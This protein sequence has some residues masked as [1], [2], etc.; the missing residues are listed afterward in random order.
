MHA[1]RVA[2]LIVLATIVA[3]GCRKKP[4]TPPDVIVR[5]T[6]RMLTLADFK[7]YLVRNTGTDLA[8]MT[9]EVASALLDQF[10][11]EIIL[12]EY[13][14][15]HGVEVPAER[16]AEAV[17]TEAGS[18]V[19]EKRDEM[20]RQKLMS[21]VTAE[22]PDPTE[23]EARTYYEEHQNEFRSGEEVHVRQILVHDEAL[24][25]DILA[26]LRKGASFADLSNEYSHAPNAKR[27]GDIG[28][29]SRGELP[30]MFEDEIFRLQP[31]Q[32]SE[33]IRTDSSFHIF[34]VDERRAPGIVDF[35]S[36]APVIAARLKEDAIRERMAQLVARSRN[37][38]QIAV[39]TR[40]LPFKYSGTYP[41][42]ENE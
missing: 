41:K 5:V 19:I 10:I 9:P 12:A 14:G 25:S 31:G 26:K 15:S 37:E 36:A 22:V 27:G 8:Q 39:L 11:E 34:R 16:I 2:L 6:D 30:K 42:V 29:V 40:R 20:R 32:F 7:R 1:R 13:A 17:R 23:N 38:I 35:E 28:F 18:T 4:A 33:V 21:D 24:A 3:I